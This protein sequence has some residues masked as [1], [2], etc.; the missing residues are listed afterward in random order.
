MT[1]QSF[2]FGY[3]QR[4]MWFTLCK[5]LNIFTLVTEIQNILWLDEGAKGTCYCVFMAKLNGFY[6]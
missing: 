3:N 6:C 2:I 4:K 5:D 1:R